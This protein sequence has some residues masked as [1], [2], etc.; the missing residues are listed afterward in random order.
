MRELFQNGGGTVIDYNYHRVASVDTCWFQ[1][2]MYV[3]I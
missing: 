3:K 2:T 1:Q